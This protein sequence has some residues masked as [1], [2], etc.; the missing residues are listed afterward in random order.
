PVVIIEFKCYKR[1]GKIF[2][3]LST[4]LDENRGK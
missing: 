4:V 2:I 3:N 1:H